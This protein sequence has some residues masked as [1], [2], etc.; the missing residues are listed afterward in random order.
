MLVDRLIELADQSWRSVF[1]Q[2]RTLQRALRSGIGS[3]IAVGRRTIT[4]SIQARS[5]S[6]E[7]DWSADYKVFSRSPWSEADL[8]DSSFTTFLQR[9]PGRQVPVALDET[10]L[11]KS[12]RQIPHTMWQRDPLSPPFHV[13]LMWGLRFLQ[14][15]VLYPHHTEGELPARGIPVAFVDAPAVKKPSRRASDQE[16]EAYKREQGQRNLSRQAVDLIVGLRARLDRLGGSDRTLLMA[17]DG[18]FCNRT[19]FRSDLD[20]VTLLARARKDARL[21]LP[22]SPGHRRKYDPNTFTPEQ[23]RLDESI[24]WRTAELRIGAVRHEFHYK[25]L[26]NVLWRGGAGLRRLRLIVIAPQ[27]YRTKGDGGKDYRQPA[28]LL[29][30]DLQTPAETLI[31]IYIDRWQIEV[32]H[33]DEKDL[34]GVGQAQVWSEQSV[35]RQPAF[36]VAL[37]S[38]L[39]LASL[40]E[41]GP[42]RTSAFAP[43]PRWRKCAI[44]PS[45]L[46]LLHL[47]RHELIEAQVSPPGF[48]IS[49][50]TLLSAA[51]T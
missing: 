29:T 46:D 7:S 8:F 1:A 4:N 41:F 6:S 19:V 48:A 14:A 3:L 27:P 31:Q 39:L 2:R 24:P 21:C 23:V 51:H 33:R 30:T 44:R 22:T 16:R 36:I 47:V 35:P 25:E 38:L 28:Y 5:P 34:L 50:P 49:A 20:R 11:H 43:L 12:G 15:S 10:K 32:N 45:L 42:G 26:S 13:N 9:Y 37:Y 40:L 17:M 18:S